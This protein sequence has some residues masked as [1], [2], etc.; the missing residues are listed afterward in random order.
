M[1]QESLRLTI[2]PTT[3]YVVQSFNKV[4][5]DCI[6]V[7]EASEDGDDIRAR[8]CVFFGQDGP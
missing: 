7:M 8:V 3:Y 1:S 2:S 6:G 4:G 5:E